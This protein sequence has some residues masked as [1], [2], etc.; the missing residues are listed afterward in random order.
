MTAQY[1]GYI[2]VNTSTSSG[3]GDGG[4]GEVVN[5]AMFYWFVESA[6]PD[7]GDL[8]IVI[9]LQGG[10]GMG[11]KDEAWMRVW[12]QGQ[13][14]RWDGFA[15]C[16]WLLPVVRWKPSGGFLDTPTT[17]P[18]LPLLKPSPVVFDL[19]RR[20]VGQAARAFTVSLWKTG[21]ITSRLIWS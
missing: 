9:W 15:G 3:G 5:A 19:F 12:T 11:S 8:P 20:F 13:R 14:A 17:D 10:P 18:F 4:D 2:A 1:S 7:N 16:C 21:R 6:A